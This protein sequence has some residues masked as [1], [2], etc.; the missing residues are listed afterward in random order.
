MFWLRGKPIRT[1][2]RGGVAWLVWSCLLII[3]LI[4]VDGLLVDPQPVGKVSALVLAAIGFG[5]GYVMWR[6]SR[7]VLYGNGILVGTGVRPRWIPR[8]ELS[9]VSLQP[10]RDLWGRAGQVP[11]LHMRSG[12]GMKLGAFF[13]RDASPGNQ[14]VAQRAAGLLAEYIKAAP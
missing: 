7:I 1:Y 3:G 4:G 2:R 10:D 11:V 8:G 6:A 5:Y 14:G 13:S 12:R 9:D